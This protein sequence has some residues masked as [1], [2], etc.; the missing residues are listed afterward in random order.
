MVNYEIGKV[1]GVF[2]DKIEIFLLDLIESEDLCIGVSEDMCINITSEEGPYPLIIGQPG[3]FVQISLPNGYLLALITDIR[4][5]E[6]SFLQKDIKEAEEE[7]VYLIE[8]PKRVLSA[9]PIG[10]IDPAGKFE[11][12]CDILPTINAKVFAVTMTA[13]EKIYQS[14]AKGDFTLGKL[15]LIPD[16]K[17]KINLDIFLGRHA[18]IIGQTGTGKSWTV[19]SILQKL[20]KFS[21]STV[22]LLDLHGEYKTS[23]KEEYAD[24]ISA[25]DLEFPYWLMNFQ[26]LLGLMIDQSEHSAPNQVAKFRDL[27]Q[28]AKEDHEENIELSIPKITI[29]TPVFFNF[30]SIIENFKELDTQMV[31][32][33][34][35]DK[36]K[37]G[38]YFGKFTKLIARIESRLND[39]RFDLIFKPNKYTSSASMESLFKRILGEN[40][41]KSSKIIIIDIS[42][43]PME[44]RNSVISLLL[45][46]IF[47]FCYW[48]KRIKGETYPIS[49]FCDE[50]HSYL[51]DKDTAFTSSRNAAE[52]LAKEGRKY[53]ISL[54]VVT[55]RPREV[56]ATILSQCNS[57]MCMRIT[58]PDDQTY[59]K[60]LLPENIGGI[61][62]MFSTLR[63][64]ECILLGDSV[65]M[66]SRIKLDV[67]DPTPSSEDTSFYDE[68]NKE[69]T[70]ID[71]KSILD[72]W[73]KQED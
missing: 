35:P 53:G 40:D 1:I 34:R 25:K 24:Y 64:G 12:G 3:T 43:I 67:P 68:W 15:S 56:S 51:N 69:H 48:Y 62:S 19:A 45:R 22:L 20:S 39:K 28:K 37:Q 57:F 26:E 27:L 18:A 9:V 30:E 31:P 41:E 70:P 65:I 29:D 58:N 44:V 13:L 49:I 36:P 11:R 6:K 4:M 63:R 54:T 46:C 2:G 72:S 38:D 42:P 50:A 52:K 47:D 73:R 23:F 66:P 8:N 60:R 59:V 5:R 61:I 7:E 32:G 14:Y 71:I 10:T 21:K 16:Q 33:A 17:A 55:Q